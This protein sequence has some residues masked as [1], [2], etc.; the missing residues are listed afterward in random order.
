M[1]AET[2]HKV[3]QAWQGP[4]SEQAG[5]ALTLRAALCFRLEAP[6]LA[7]PSESAS[8]STR[9]K[10]PCAGALGP[11][12]RGQD[13]P[14]SCP[15]P[16]PRAT[17]QNTRDSECTRASACGLDPRGP[18]LQALMGRALPAVPSVTRP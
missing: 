8:R 1:E 7:T 18:T 9:R 6:V 11:A 4:G 5:A 17:V 3:Q 13:C 2:R 16:R 15:L 12:R 10:Q 14:P